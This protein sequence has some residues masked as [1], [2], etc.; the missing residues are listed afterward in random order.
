MT[1]EYQCAAEMATCS[2]S[3]CGITY[4]LPLNYARSR[5]RDG[6]SWRCPNGHSQCFG[7]GENA[8]LRKELSRLTSVIDQEKAATRTAREERD[9]ADRRTVAQKAVVTRLKNKAAKGECPCC[10]KLF[11]DLEAH[12]RETHPDYEARE[13]S[14]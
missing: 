9:A 12:M 4:G 3:E 7:E 11:V 13:E 1:T 10:D 8:K 2:C 6:Q 14:Q 5:Q